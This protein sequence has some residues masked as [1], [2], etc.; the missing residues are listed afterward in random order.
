M[1]RH[2]FLQRLL[3]S[4]TFIIRARRFFISL[5][6][7]YNTRIKGKCRLFG[8]DCE[9]RNSHI[10]PKFVIDYFKETGSR[11]LRTFKEPNRRQQ[12]GLK[13]YFLSEKAEQRFSIN[14]KW[15]AENIFKP[16]LKQQRI[17]F[18]YDEH[19]FYFA[20]SLLWRIL[21]LKLEENIKESD[22]NFSL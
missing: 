14:E 19:L 15:F 18:E 8:D 21:V 9:L 13:R 12:D 3:E 4:F 20:I 2:S 17:I 1:K 7:N 6:F 22:P 5:C 11:F 16:Y 10:F